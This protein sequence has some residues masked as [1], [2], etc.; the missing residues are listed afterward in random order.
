MKRFSSRLRLKT[1]SPA[2][3]SVVPA[4]MPNVVSVGAFPHT[5]GSRN[6]RRNDVSGLKFS[7]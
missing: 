5:I 4:A 1:A 7:Y 3:S 6:N 2:T